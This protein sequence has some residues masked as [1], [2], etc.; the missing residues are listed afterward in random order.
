LVPAPTRPGLDPNE[1]ASA[2]ASDSVRVAEAS[3]PAV[4]VADASGEVLVALVAVVVTCETG[5]VDVVVAGGLGTMGT[6][7]VVGSLGTVVVVGSLGTVV[8]VGSLGTVVVVG[9]LGTVVVVG[10]FGSVVE[11]GSGTVVVT[12]GRAVVSG[13]LVVGSWFGPG[14]AAKA[15]P[16]QTPRANRNPRPAADL[17]PIELR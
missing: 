2:A 1:R 3:E 14:A 4:L 17:M 10:S 13:R 5:F 15:C 7:V 12:F 11:V 6:V 9:S 8:V 16:T